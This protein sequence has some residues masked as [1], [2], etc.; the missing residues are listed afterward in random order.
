MSGL[1]GAA[2]PVNILQYVGT[3]QHVDTDYSWCDDWPPLVV[4]ACIGFGIGPTISWENPWW[5][6]SGFTEQT[7]DGGGAF[8]PTGVGLNFYVLS[9]NLVYPVA[10]CNGRFSWAGVARDQ[11]GSAITTGATV[12]LF[13]SSTS[14][15]Q[16]QVT[17][18]SNGYFLVTSAYNEA[19]FITVHATGIGGASVDTL[20]P[21]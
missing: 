11:Y 16:A 19:H 3:P 6:R 17:A 1:I 9:P 7:T 15:L 5:P 12:R 14:E 21:F 13:R 2:L 4:Q 18:D 8:V 10:G 20:T